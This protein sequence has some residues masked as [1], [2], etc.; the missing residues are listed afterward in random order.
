MSNLDLFDRLPAVAEPLPAVVPVVPEVVPEV[1]PAV[2][3]PVVIVPV[4]PAVVEG[5]LWVIDATA[6]LFRAFFGM[7]PRYSPSGVP[8]GAVLGLSQ[9][10]LQVVRRNRAR[11]IALVYDA[12]RETFRN[13]LDPRYKAQRGEPPPELV[14]QF[15]LALRLGQA[16]G[17]AAY[18][19]PDF[20]A[21]DLM[22]TLAC[23]ARAVGV[24]ARLVSVDKDVC[25]LVRDAGPAVV[26]EDPKKGDIL[27]EAGV[28]QR[29]GVAPAHVVDVMALTGDSSDN[30]PGVRGVGPMAAVALI[31]A[32]GDLE[33]I[34]ADLGRVEALTLRGA[35]GLA[36]K[37]EAGRAEAFLARDLVRLCDAVPIDGLGAG[38][39]RA[40]V[41]TGTGGLLTQTSW[42]GPGA[43]AGELFDEIGTHGALRAFAA[44]RAW[45]G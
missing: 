3:V 45:I 7:P 33:G 12:G 24:G 15:E 6:L 27:N 14:P 26:V 9:L 29:M 2:I 39:G 5:E 25:Q 20:E 18:S 44:L 38:P 37:L 43:D 28:R 22:A 17:F 21:D 4:V 13:R 36:R 41:P 10:L 32:F 23:Q 42:R 16:L 35:K 8:I 31:E 30:I 40:A 34:Y 19:V 1:V 11:R